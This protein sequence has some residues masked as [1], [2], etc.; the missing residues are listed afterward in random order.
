ML[1]SAPSSS[2]FETSLTSSI[3]RCRPRPLQGGSRSVR[4]PPPGGFLASRLSASLVDLA[5]SWGRFSLPAIPLTFL[6]AA[7]FTLREWS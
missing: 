4:V 1:A 5:K 3:V 2:L 7:G 6:A